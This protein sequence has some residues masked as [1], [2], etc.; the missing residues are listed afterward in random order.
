MIVFRCESNDFAHYPI[1]DVIVD[2]C[3]G[4]KCRA[5]FVMT[6]SNDGCR[7][8]LTEHWGLGVEAASAD[9]VQPK[10]SAQRFSLN[11]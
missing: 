10:A 11:R 1:D 7:C 6:P 8:V 5:G 9:K 4:L 3:L 2:L